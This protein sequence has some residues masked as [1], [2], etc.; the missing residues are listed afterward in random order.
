MPDIAIGILRMRNF[1]AP[2]KRNVLLK[3]G[4]CFVKVLISLV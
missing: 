4:I 1:V 3:Q 2:D